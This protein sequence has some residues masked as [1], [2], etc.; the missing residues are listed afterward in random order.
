MIT[1]L[2]SK[3][4]TP[5]S[6]QPQA[7]TRLHAAVV[8]GIGAVQRLRRELGDTALKLQ[9][10]TRNEYGYT[11]LMT[12]CALSDHVAG[13]AIVSELVDAVGEGASVV[14]AVDNEGFSALHWAAACGSALIVRKLLAI[15]A[16]PNIRSSKVSA[17]HRPAQTLGALTSWMGGRG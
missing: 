15:G 17:A 12:A 10:R 7:S 5:V 3:C 2:L 13:L 1:S 16:N 4:Q 6:V 9:M 8:K 14:E 11:P